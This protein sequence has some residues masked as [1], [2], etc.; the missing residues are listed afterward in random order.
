MAT[1]VVDVLLEEVFEEV[2]SEDEALEVVAICE[3][4]VL[5]DALDLE[6]DVLVGSTE[7]STEVAQDVLST[8]EVLPGHSG[9]IHATGTTV[10]L[11]ETEQEEV[12]IRDV[13]PPRGAR[14]CP[15]RPAAGAP[16]PR[17]RRPKAS[18]ENMILD[19]PYQSQ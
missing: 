18:L 19:P 8:K 12:V 14:S 5:A 2:V 6:V 7:V 16:S 3:L 17:Y 15:G 9:L 4:D 13:P 1:P 11:V 10:V